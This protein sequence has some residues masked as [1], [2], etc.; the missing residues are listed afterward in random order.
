MLVKQHASLMGRGEGEGGRGKYRERKCVLRPREY[1]SHG[2]EQE[3]HFDKFE[4]P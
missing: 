2:Q 3:I 4:Y 1:M